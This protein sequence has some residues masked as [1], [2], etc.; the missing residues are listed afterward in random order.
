MDEVKQLLLSGEHEKRMA[1]V[2]TCAI[3]WTSAYVALLC[4]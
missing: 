4:C 3:G 2:D 1:Q